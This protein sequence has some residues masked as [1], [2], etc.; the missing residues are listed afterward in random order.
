LFARKQK[1]ENVTIFLDGS[2]FVEC[3]FDNCTLIYSGLLPVA[4]D[5]SS[6]N[7]CRWEFSGAAQN[8][9]GLMAA[10]YGSGEQELIE[11]TFDNIR[12]KPNPAAVITKY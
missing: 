10:L 5:T 4:L 2:S 3:T 8:T 12:G 9:V 6:F 1:F 7:N 11:A